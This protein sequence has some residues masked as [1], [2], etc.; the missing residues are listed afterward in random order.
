MKSR[1]TSSYGITL[2]ELIVVIAIWVILF[3][4]AIPSFQQYFKRQ[5]LNGIADNLHFLLRYAKAESAKKSQRMWLK[6]QVN[7]NDDKIWRVALTDTTACEFTAAN[8]CLINGIVREYTNA[9][10]QGV[11]LKTNVNSIS[12]DPIRGRGNA[13]TI[14]FAL[15]GMNIEFRK[16]TYGNHKVCTNFS[17]TNSRYPACK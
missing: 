9:Q 13:G 16:N 5:K 7:E 8:P 1:R 10:Y 15:N 4:L 6:I 12:I 11:S 2:I 3:T 14:R 17:A